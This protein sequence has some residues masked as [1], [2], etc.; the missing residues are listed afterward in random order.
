M[1]GH[2]EILLASARSAN[3]SL[4]TNSIIRAGLQ[5]GWAGDANIWRVRNR[6]LTPA[7]RYVWEKRFEIGLPKS[8][9]NKA[10]GA[11]WLYLLELLGI[12]KGVEYKLG[13]SSEKKQY[14]IF[15]GHN[16]WNTSKPLTDQASA[17]Y[18]ITKGES[19]TVCLYW[20]DF[21]Q[22]RVRK[23]YED[24]GFKLECVGFLG[25]P[26]SSIEN[27]VGRSD[28]LLEL[29][30]L[31]LNHRT[32]VA[33]EFSSGVLYGATLGLEV[34]FMD[35]TRTR[36]HD[37]KLSHNRDD[38]LEGFYLT[39]N[40]WLDNFFPE[41]YLTRESGRKFVDFSY[42]ELGADSLLMPKELAEIE[43]IAS[44]L[45]GQIQI[46]FEKSVK[47]LRSCIFKSE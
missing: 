21:L 1:Y 45:D 28:F 35:D 41:I 4:P 34:M 43:W 26:A 38:S 39:S 36:E 11:P 16:M 30:K 37:E 40:E 19:A 9:R 12:E 42:Q 31:M 13:S 25:S 5:H 24:L 22:P 33:D 18:E 27:N 46:E 6:N 2:R 32:I 44:S 23:A 29:V 7:P 20:I 8:T 47:S 15:P 14:L 10:I 17:F 3:Q